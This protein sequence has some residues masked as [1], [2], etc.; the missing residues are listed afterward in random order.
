MVYV[1][2]LEALIRAVNTTIVM[3]DDLKKGGSVNF[4][5]LS[6]MTEEHLNGQLRS[7]YRRNNSFEVIMSFLSRYNLSMGF[8]Q[9]RKI[10]IRNKTRDYQDGITYTDN[11]EYATILLKSE[12]EN[13]II[14][15]LFR[16]CGFY[17][18]LLLDEA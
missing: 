14:E 13:S 18:D 5:R 16:I 3:I 7:S 10:D 17:C 2:P 12:D 1:A 8:L 9:K 6:T 4:S 15:S 11:I